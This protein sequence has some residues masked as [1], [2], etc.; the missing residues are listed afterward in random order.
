MRSANLFLIFF[1]L[2]SCSVNDGSQL[3]S[4]EFQSSWELVSFI[5]EKGEELILYDYE[6]HTLRFNKN[7]SELG[8]E[9]ACN[10]Y[11]GKYRAFKNGSMSI[12]NLVVTEALCRQPSWGEEFVNALVD[13]SEFNKNGGELILKF[14][15]KG[16]L[17]FFERLE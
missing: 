8:G 6:V 5:D 7:E 11:G 17:K 16:K 14:G 1:L 10:Y 2:T 4:I 12:Q 13:V 3:S 9:T 15:S